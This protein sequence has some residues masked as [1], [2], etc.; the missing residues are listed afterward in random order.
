MQSGGQKVCGEI[1]I[2]YALLAILKDHKTRAFAMI[3]EDFK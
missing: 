1:G 3:T 2:V